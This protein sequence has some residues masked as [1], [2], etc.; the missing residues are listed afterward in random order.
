M[1]VLEYSDQDVN[2][3]FRALAD[4]TRRD[5]VRRTLVADVSVSQLADSY[6]MSFAAVQKHVA[7]LEEA[8]LVTKEPRG[9]ERMV[10]GN[11]DRIREAQ[12]LLDRFEDLWRSR[13]DRLD[14]LLAEDDPAPPDT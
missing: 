6:E 9:R 14:I 11:P 2:R 7:V 8:R 5:I 4:A 3:L 13:I 10:R 1:V 12:R